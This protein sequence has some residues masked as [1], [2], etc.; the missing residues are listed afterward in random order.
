[1]SDMQISF[2]IPIK[3]GNAEALSLSRLLFV[4]VDMQHM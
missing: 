4:A 1:M 2:R 3:V